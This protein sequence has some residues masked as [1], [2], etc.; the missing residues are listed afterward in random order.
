MNDFCH[1]PHTHITNST[2]GN[3]IAILGFTVKQFVD[4]NSIISIC[5]RYEILTS[6]A[7]YISLKQFR[8]AQSDVDVTH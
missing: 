8:N 2:T 6:Q 5:L 3:I 7:L 1:V 4:Q